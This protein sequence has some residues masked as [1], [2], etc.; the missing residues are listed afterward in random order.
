MSI[1]GTE[2]ADALTV[3]AF[4]VEGVGLAWIA[5]RTAFRCL[6]EGAQVFGPRNALRRAQE[7]EAFVVRFVPSCASALLGIA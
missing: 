7:W 4:A 2:A 1:P 5:V 6:V 3:L